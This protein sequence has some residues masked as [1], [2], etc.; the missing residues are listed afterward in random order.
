MGSENGSRCRGVSQL[1]S[2][3]SRYS[4][5]LRLPVYLVEV[6]GGPLGCSSRRKIVLL[7]ETLGPVTP[8]G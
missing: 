8:S 7:S 3:Q 2:H 4:V 5:Q 6:F 1:Q